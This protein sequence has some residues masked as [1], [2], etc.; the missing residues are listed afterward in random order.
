MSSCPNPRDG[1]NCRISQSERNRRITFRWEVMQ[2]VPRV[3]N[4]FKEFLLKI[5]SSQLKR[6]SFI[7]SEVSVV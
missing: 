7:V 5:V 6:L 1:V 4:L 2:T 3:A